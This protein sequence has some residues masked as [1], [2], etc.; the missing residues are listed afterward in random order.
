[1][2]GLPQ[3][4][5]IAFVVYSDRMADSYDKRAAGWNPFNLQPLQWEASYAGVILH[6]P[7]VGEEAMTKVTG[8]GAEFSQA[9]EHTT[10]Q[11]IT[12]ISPSLTSLNKSKAPRGPKGGILHTGRLYSL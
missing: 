1:M 4:K 6:R 10:L 3:G 2:L 11:V 5:G 9:R 12:S 8:G 7:A